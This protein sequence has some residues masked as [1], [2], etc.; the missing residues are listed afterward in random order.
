MVSNIREITARS[1]GSHAKPGSLPKC[2]ASRRNYS[3]DHPVIGETT[4]DQTK[5]SNDPANGKKDEHQTQAK[6]AGSGEGRDHPAKQ[7]DP[8][9]SPSKSTGFE[10][11]GPGSKSG[12]GEDKGV[13]KDRGAGP[14]MKQ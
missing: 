11:E 5:H 8:Q 10:T 2:L 9:Q 12:A 7:P 3:S 6:K 4:V 1:L 14:F 13:S